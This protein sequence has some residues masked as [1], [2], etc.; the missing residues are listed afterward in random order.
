MERMPVRGR[1]EEELGLVGRPYSR[2]GVVVRAWRKYA[3]L[4]VT[5]L[6]VRVGLGEAG[7]S[8]ISQIEHGY[9]QQLGWERLQR[10][11]TALGLT[12]EDLM[13]QKMPPSLPVTK[14]VRPQFAPSMVPPHLMPDDQL[15]EYTDPALETAQI[16]RWQPVFDRHQ[17]IVIGLRDVTANDTHLEMNS[18]R[19]KVSH[20][21]D[22]K[23]IVPQSIFRR[24]E[25]LQA[26]GVPF[27][28][29]LWAEH[30]LPAAQHTFSCHILLIGVVATGDD[31][32]VWCLLGK[33]LQ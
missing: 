10:M 2:L 22:S 25:A 18:V 32:G 1:K 14:P 27:N 29:W 13:S 11:A 16:A 30:R 31:R 20:L 33:W 26:E 12:P 21:D 6:A 9:I 8:Y 3:G 19:W 23:H 24:V 15:F 28:W 7:K 4:S 17:V 5:E